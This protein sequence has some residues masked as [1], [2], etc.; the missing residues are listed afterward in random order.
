MSSLAN[1]LFLFIQVL[2]SKAPMTVAEYGDSYALIGPYNADSA[3]IEFEPLDPSPLTASVIN[4][5]LE[6]HKVY[7][8]L[9]IL[10]LFPLLF[11][12]SFLSSC[13]FSSSS[14]LSFLPSSH[15]FVPQSKIKIY[16]G[17]WLVKGY[18]RVFLIDVNSSTTKLGEWR[19]ELMFGFEPVNDE[20]GGLD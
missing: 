13:L 7:S 10:I 14:F 9:I 19:K 4:Y 5:L 11:L 15:H 1:F 3:A 8:L 2:R 12:F 20:E 16:F 18:P 17:R 6:T